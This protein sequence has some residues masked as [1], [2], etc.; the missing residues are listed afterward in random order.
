MR[1]DSGMILGWKFNNAPGITTVDGVIRDWPAA[2]GE[3][4]TE[5]EIDAWGIEYDNMLATTLSA[6]QLELDNEEAE[7]LTAFP[8]WEQIETAIDNATLAE[9]KTIIKRGFKALYNLLLW[10]KK[11]IAEARKNL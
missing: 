8:S 1:L 5:A 7:I 6:A 9:M 11:V 3:K 10:R 2:L 4:P